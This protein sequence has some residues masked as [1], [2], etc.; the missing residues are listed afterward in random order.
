MF[1]YVFNLGAHDLREVEVAALCSLSP[2]LT[3]LRISVDFSLVAE[4]KKPRLA[5][6]G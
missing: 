3:I 4:L 5:Q 6:D 2:S 1:T